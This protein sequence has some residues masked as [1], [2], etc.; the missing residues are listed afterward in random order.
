MIA[1][2][3]MTTSSRALTSGPA[4]RASPALAGA[5]RLLLRL[6]GGVVLAVAALAYSHSGHGCGLFALWFLVPD[7]SMLGYL[8]GPRTGSATYNAGHS[9]VSP[10]LL[11]LAGL[12]FAWPV[13]WPLAMI[14][15]AHVGF[16]RLLG[17]GLKYGSAFGHTHLGRVGK[18][19]V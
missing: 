13:A 17:Y 4:D 5:P 8:L 16:D 19:R 14:W 9:Y 18:A 10:A 12:A 6:E 7:L 11:G 15:A 3:P 1:A 2:A